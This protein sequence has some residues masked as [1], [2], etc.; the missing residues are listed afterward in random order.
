MT[1]QVTV[2]PD[3]FCATSVAADY[4]FHLLLTEYLRERAGLDENALQQA[5]P[6]FRKALRKTG[7]VVLIRAI[8]ARI[9]WIAENERELSEP[10]RWQDFLA[11][12]ARQLYSPSLP[13][14]EA[15]L[16]AL[17]KSHRE[18]RAL[19]RFGPE[20]LLAA[21]LETHDISPALGAEMRRFQEELKGAPGKMKYENQS[22]YQVAVAQFHMLL[23]HDDEEPLQPSRCWSEIVRGDL[24]QMD[25]KRREHWKALLRHIKGNA[26]A[27][28]PA[29]WLKAAE[30]HLAQIGH[31][32]FADRFAAWLAPFRSGEPQPLSVP[33]SHLLR[34][35]LWYA[36]MLNDPATARAALVL[37]DATWKA[38]R[39]VDKVMTAL[40]GVLEALPA[41]EA[42]P[43]IVRLQQEWP[44]GSLQ[45]MRLI[46]E[47]A[48]KLGGAEAEQARTLLKPKVEFAEHVDRL[49]DQMLDRL[50]KSNFLIGIRPP[51]NR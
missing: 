20:A 28:P 21:Y 47:T 23:W 51:P 30:T 11:Q 12:L 41:D 44:T 22:S 3:G 26:P 39:N 38:K 24:R 31:E 29:G 35:L 34:G 43:H 42:W 25:G 50:G 7:L 36:A 18:H 15:D 49:M 27:K 46:E 2:G 1:M 19:W 33:G 9:G 8:H 48:A 4:E 13:F 32:D 5:L 37:L 10:R 40:V 45:V 17:L 14:E 16:I 6:R